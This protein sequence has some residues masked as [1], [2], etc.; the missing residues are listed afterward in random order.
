MGTVGVV[1]RKCG[2]EVCNH[3]GKV[4]GHCE[5]MWGSTWGTLEITLVNIWDRF[6]ELGSHV[7]EAYSM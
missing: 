5:K 6:R 7:G 1:L 3:L 2:G 4:Q